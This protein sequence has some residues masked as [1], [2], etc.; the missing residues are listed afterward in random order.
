MIAAGRAL[1]KMLRACARGIQ[2]TLHM[3][4]QSNA[5]QIMLHAFSEAKGIA[6]KLIHDC[7]DCAMPNKYYVQPT[8]DKHAANLAASS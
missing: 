3:Q 8:E 6:K 7:V 2:K 1:W 4:R 5:L